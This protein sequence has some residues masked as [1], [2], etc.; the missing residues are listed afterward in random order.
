MCQ[1]AHQRHSLP[2]QAQ[3]Q[4]LQLQSSR[5]SHPH[6]S[7][8]RKNVKCT[9]LKKKKKKTVPNSTMLTCALSGTHYKDDGNAGCK[10][11]FAQVQLYKQGYRD[12]KSVV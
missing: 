3:H 9:D 7:E 6:I 11:R 2:T 5:Q 4:R 10:G 1:H 8:G 12:R